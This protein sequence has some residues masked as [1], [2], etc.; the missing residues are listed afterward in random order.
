M[1]LFP[2]IL[3]NLAA[4]SQKV[5]VSPLPSATSDSMNSIKNREKGRQALKT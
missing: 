2:Y 5:P 1:L 4:T 3:I